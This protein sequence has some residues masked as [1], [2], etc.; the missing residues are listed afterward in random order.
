MQAEL[1]AAEQEKQTLLQQTQVALQSCERHKDLE[2]LSSGTY[3]AGSAKDQ[4]LQADSPLPKAPLPLN[5][6]KPKQPPLRSLSWGGGPKPFS[7]PNQQPQRRSTFNLAD[8]APGQRRGMPQKQ[9]VQQEIIQQWLSQE[10]SSAAASGA[11]DMDSVRQEVLQQV[12]Q[13]VTLT[14]QGPTHVDFNNLTVQVHCRPR[15]CTL[16]GAQCQLC[17]HSKPLC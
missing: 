12:L 15:S 16:Q 3:G 9:P 4:I 1:A 5:H 2:D 6:V 11:V 14:T 7:K 17:Y 13:A 10:Q 8:A